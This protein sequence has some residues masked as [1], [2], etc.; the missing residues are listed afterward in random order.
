MIPAAAPLA[1]DGVFHVQEAPVVSAR[2]HTSRG[3]GHERVPAID[4]CGEWP[5][6]RALEEVPVRHR[7]IGCWA[8]LAVHLLAIGRR[9]DHV[10]I[11]IVEVSV[12]YAHAQR[13]RP[14]N[15]AVGEASAQVKARLLAI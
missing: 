1:V 15:A 3:V 2:I 6:A 10:L 7:A 8:A 4:R 13:A 12:V 14:R 11:G 9:A 5:P